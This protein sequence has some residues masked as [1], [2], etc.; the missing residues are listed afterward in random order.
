MTI[1]RPSFNYAP[2][3]DTTFVDPAHPSTGAVTAMAVSPNG[4]YLASASLG[5]RGEVKIWSVEKR[6][7]LWRCVMTFI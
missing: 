3:P 5:Q 2:S 6:R 7:I 1:S 4:L